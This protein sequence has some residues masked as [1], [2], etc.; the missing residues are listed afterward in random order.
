VLLFIKQVARQAGEILLENLN[1]LKS[2]SIREKKGHRDLVTD[3]DEL[4]EKFIVQ[5]IEEK[6]PDHS[7]IAEE[8]AKKQNS[9]LYTWYIDP[10]DGT[11]NYIHSNPAFCVSIGLWY[12]NEANIGVVYN[13]YYD[14]LF[15]AEKN[16]GAYLENYRFKKTKERLEVTNCKTLRTSL[17]ATGFACR[18]NDQAT[19]NYKIFN[20]M[21]DL[22]QGV[23]RLGS[24]ALDLCFV[25]CGRFDGYWEMNLNP[26]DVS[27][28][29]LIVK[30]A[31]GSVTDFKGGNNYL[32]GKTII[33]SNSHIHM[34]II[35]EIKKFVT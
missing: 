30:E 24:A 13:P 14:E 26:W 3:I 32:Y 23:R 8:H 2:S 6:Y 35:N 1:K 21:V 29:S 20:H 9:S 27:A 22:S 5:K 16:A 12:K 17:L 33:A 7:I 28:G 31:G 4:S 10:I 15:F 11:T 25:A 19:P 18:R 34:K